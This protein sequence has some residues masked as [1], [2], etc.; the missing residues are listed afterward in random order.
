[1]DAQETQA[2]IEHRL[3]TV[4]WNNDPAFTPEAHAAIYGYTGGIPRMTNALCDRL[5][6]MG[7]LELGGEF[8]ETHAGTG[9]D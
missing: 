2:Y 1:M 9:R 4:G 6:L 5:L 7:F 3:H 8:V